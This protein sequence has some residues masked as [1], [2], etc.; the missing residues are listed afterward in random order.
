MLKVDA[1]DELYLKYLS[2]P[3]FYNNTPNKEWDHNRLFEF[4]ENIFTSPQNPVAQRRWFS[5]LSRWR[6]AKRV[7][8]RSEKG[9]PWP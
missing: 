4:M 5:K 1:D 2:A 7:K 3:P 8:T 9:I 6:L